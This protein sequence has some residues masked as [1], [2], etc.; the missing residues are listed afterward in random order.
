MRGAVIVARTRDALHRGLAQLKGRGRRLGLVPTMGF[1]HEGHLSLVDLAGEASDAVAV[2]VFVNPLQFAPGEDLAAYPRDEARD[3]T[4]LEGRGAALAFL[5]SVEEM[6]PRGEPR[7]AVDPG[8]LAER[9]CGTFRPGHFRGMLTVVA[10]LFGLVRPDVAAFGR[11]DLQQSVL[12]RHMARDLEMGTEILVG[13]VIR[14]ADGLAMS[15][16][17]AY[18]S[19]EERAQAVGLS[20]GLFAAREAFRGGERSAD[21]L[22]STFREVLGRHAALRLQYAAI[23]EPDALEP[24][25]PAAEGCVAAAAVFAGTTRLIDNVVLE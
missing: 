25:D 14:E 12:I 9:L 13:P 8:P 15:S 10:R 22:L 6:Y 3:L 16:R 7:V 20:R 17:N 23:V 1:L 24:V 19:P 18:L 2:S 11:K 21:E 5:P 4:L